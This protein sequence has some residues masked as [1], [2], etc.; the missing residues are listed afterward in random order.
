MSRSINSKPV[1]ILGAGGH[2]KVLADS[3]NCSGYKILGF[4]TPD[5]K[6]GS[7]FY[8]YKV[9]GDDS[10]VAKYLPSDVI[11]ANGIG[12][13]PY[14]TLRWD[15]AMKFRDKGYCFVTIVHPSAI[16][17]ENVVLEEGVQVMSGSVIQTDVKIG[18]DTIIN[19]GALI[20]HDCSIANN[21][22]VSPGAI[23][24]G[25]VVV[26]KNSYIGIGAKILQQV[27][28][29]ENSVVASGTLVCKDVPVGVTIK[30]RLDTLV[31][32]K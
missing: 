5:I 24:S 32:K 17:A 2:A 31:E 10:I 28:I 22:Q 23:L 13:L 16:I 29:N 9:L 3:L 19:T 18:C 8:N 30:Q 27:K 20:D 7:C 21:C 1:I 15:L 26:K 11:L 14:K 12:A 4:V 25:S 6:P